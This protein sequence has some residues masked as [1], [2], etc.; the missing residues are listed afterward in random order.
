MG[1]LRGI[2]TL[3]I[4]KQK[5]ISRRFFNASTAS[6][7]PEVRTTAAPVWDYPYAKRL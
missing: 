3:A 7:H 5:N 4:G 2:E 6:I 1:I